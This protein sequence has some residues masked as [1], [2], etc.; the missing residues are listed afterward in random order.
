MKMQVYQCACFDSD[1]QRKAH[2]DCRPK[3]ASLVNNES[4]S[5]YYMIISL[6]PFSNSVPLLFWSL[7]K[8]LLIIGPEKHNLS[9]PWVMSFFGTS[10]ATVDRLGVENNCCTHTQTDRHYTNLY[11]DVL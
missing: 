7:G 3:S 8:H 1:C 6:L 5:K 9:L 10:F 11:L 2:C 4:L